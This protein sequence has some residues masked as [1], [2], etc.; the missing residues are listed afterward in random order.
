MENI[1]SHFQSSQ[2]TSFEQLDPSRY[3]TGE[4]FAVR[5]RKIQTGGFRPYKALFYGK[6][7]QH[8]LRRRFK[9][10][11]Q[12]TVKGDKLLLN[13]KWSRGCEKM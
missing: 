12:G 10:H 8:H 9:V 1:K 5:T 6:S 7:G 13:L 2:L 3:K 4:H 11:G